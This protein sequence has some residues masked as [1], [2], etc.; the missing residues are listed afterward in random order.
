M[1]D[2]DALIVH[3]MRTP[4]GKRRGGSYGHHKVDLS[5]HVPGAEM[6]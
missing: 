6:A 2:R 5:A 3:G 1:P 4:I